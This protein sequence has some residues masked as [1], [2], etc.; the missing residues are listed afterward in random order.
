MAIDSYAA[1]VLLVI[2][3]AAISVAGLFLV[4][5]K[6]KP[7]SLHESHEVAGYMLSI[8]GTMYAVLL[9]LVVVDAMAKFQDARTNV[10]NEANSIADVFLLSEQY[11]PQKERQIKDLC[12]HY[13]QRVIDVE[14]PAMDDGNIDPEARRTAIELIRAVRDFEPTTQAQQQIYSIAVQEVCQIWDCRRARTNTSQYGVPPEEWLVLFIGY[15]VTIVFTYF[16]GLKNIRMQ[17]AMTVMCSILISLNMLLVLW[18]G[19]PFSG[20]RKVH[21]EAFQVDKL[22]FLNQL[23]I[24]G[25]VG[26]NRS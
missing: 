13:V 22:I 26:K 3:F 9:G 15:L 12:L 17:M 11:P 8:V 4:R 10:Q 23:G 21:P 16:F 24:H 14:W 5:A 20:D 6:V 1:G 19:Y 7:E 25:E 18:F 2:L